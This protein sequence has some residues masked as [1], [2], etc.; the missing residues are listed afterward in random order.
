MMKS[1]DQLRH[2]L[3]RQWHNRSIRLTRLLTQDAWPVE[4]PIGKPSSSLIE[5]NGAAIKAHI[6]AWQ[7]VNHGT[8]LWQELGF[9]GLATAI[10]LPVSWQLDKPSHWV[11]ATCNAQ[12]QHEYGLLDSVLADSSAAFR[13]LLISQPRLWRDKLPEELRN[14]LQLAEK[15]APGLAGG[16]PLRALADYEIDTKFFARNERLLEAL[17]DL[18]FDGAAS[19]QG[20]VDF[21]GAQKTADHW[22]LVVPLEE[23]LLPFSRCRVSTQQLATIELPAQRILIVENEQCEHLLPRLGNTL[24]ILGAGRDLN[25]LAAAAFDTK[26]LMYWG[27]IDTWGL[28]M[29]ANVRRLRPQVQAVLMNRQTFDSYQAKNAVIEQ[30]NGSAATPVGLLAE[31][32]QLYQELIKLERGRLE[33]EFIAASDVKAALMQ[34]TD[35][36]IYLYPFASPT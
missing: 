13:D 20:L 27:D 29:L 31:E 36:P 5:A 22:L 2:T 35:L 24:A 28:D 7:G 32:A 25:W 34:C 11:D 30:V 12:V 6:K 4:L 14:C 3:T 10:R 8:V 9:R 1:P 21:L 19:E 23:G 17:L 15:M 18:R 16:R 33:Q 26:A